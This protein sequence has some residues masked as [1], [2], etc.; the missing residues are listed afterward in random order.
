MSQIPKEPEQVMKMR[1]GGVLGKRTILKSDHFPGCQN[2]RLSPQIE[3]APNYRQVGLLRLFIFCQFI[4]IYIY[5]Y[6]FFFFPFQKMNQVVN[7]VVVMVRHRTRCM[8]TVLP[9]QPL[10][11]FGT[12]STTLV[13]D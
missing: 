8:F 9:Y 12:F 7:V 3:G 5:I 10:M 4:Y 6:F 2:K 1:G 13:L 11:E